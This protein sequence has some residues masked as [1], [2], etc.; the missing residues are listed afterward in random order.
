MSSFIQEITEAS[1]K[2]VSSLS[3]LKEYFP[4]L[5]LQHLHTI[6]SVMAQAP[7]RKKRAT[8]RKP[9]KRAKLSKVL[10]KQPTNLILQKLTKHFQDSE[11]TARDAAEVMKSTTATITPTLLSL[12]RQGKIVKT[13][14]VFV[15]KNDGS[16]STGKIST[17]KIA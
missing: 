3:V 2:F 9:V 13:G 10:Q 12:G 11:F 17:Y 16:N 8:L 5:E 7:V 1:T 15:K 14:D 6:A 4:E